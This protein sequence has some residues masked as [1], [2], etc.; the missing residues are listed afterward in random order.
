MIVEMAEVYINQKVTW[1]EGKEGGMER[2]RERGGEGREREGEGEGE[3]RGRERER[4]RE[5]EQRTGKTE[6]VFI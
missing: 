4:E 5:R 6:Q 1:E 2:E 3:G